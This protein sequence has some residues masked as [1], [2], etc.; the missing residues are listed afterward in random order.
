MAQR[1]LQ[2]RGQKV[3]KSQ[4]TKKSAVKQFLLEMAHGQDWNNGS[5]N[6][7]INTGRGKVMGSMPRPRTTVN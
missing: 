3:C 4:S 5:I 2:K 7:C 6:E 1:T